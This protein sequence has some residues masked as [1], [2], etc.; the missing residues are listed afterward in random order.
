[1]AR[2]RA[3]FRA[4]ARARLEGGVIASGLSAVR[5]AGESVPGA[6]GW[7]GSESLVIVFAAFGWHHQRLRF[8]NSRGSSLVL[9]GPIGAT[10][11]GKVH[12][13]RPLRSPQLEPHDRSPA[14]SPGRGRPLPGQILPGLDGGPLD[15]WP[16]LVAVQL[17]DL[18]RRD[19]APGVC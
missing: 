13:Y 10:C 9:A 18:A 1:M 8:G 16:P 19:D 14:V 17:P 6:V 15:F 7:R 4:P 11:K 3:S 5:W 12:A 2:G